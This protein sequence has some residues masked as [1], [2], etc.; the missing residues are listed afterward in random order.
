MDRSR[1]KSYA[2]LSLVE[3]WRVEVEVPIRRRRADEEGSCKGRRDEEGP[4]GRP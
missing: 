1:N 3:T 2:T 4:L